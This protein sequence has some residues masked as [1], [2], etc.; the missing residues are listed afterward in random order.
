MAPSTAGSV[1]RLV[2]DQHGVVAHHQLRALGYGSEA[3]RHR[4][5]TGRLHPKARGVYAVGRPDLT[6]HGR[7]MVAVLACGPRA[8]ISHGTAPG[9]VELTVPGE[10]SRRRRGVRVHCRTRLQA[11]DAGL[12]LNIP[13]TSPTRTLVDIAPPLSRAQLE[14]AINLADSL[15]LVDPEALREECTRFPGER[16]VRK[17]RTVLDHRTFRATDSRLEQRFL[18]IVRRTSLPLP[19]T[20]RRVDGFRTDFVW[21]AIGLVVETDS[22]RYHRTPAQQYRDH[23]R[24][25]AHFAA[26]RYPLRFTHAQVF[27]EAPYVQ[28]MLADAERRLTV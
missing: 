5:L 20:Q 12:H 27:Y 21:P 15:D 17:L 28:V 6:W 4:V 18:A 10:R 25:Q 24:D 9:A 3:I 14:R 1:W 19:V 13:V 16:G 26:R 23:R 11:S 2:S 8:L 7:L 22:L